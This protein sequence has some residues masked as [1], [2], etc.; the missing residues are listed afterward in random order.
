MT[1]PSLIVVNSLVVRGRVGSRA[2]AFALERLGIEPWLLPTILLPFHPGHGAGTRLSV[3]EAQFAGL[4]DDLIARGLSGVRA[5]LTGYLGTVEQVPHLL[6]LI[7]AARAANPDVL[8]CCDPVIGDAQGLYVDEALALAMLESLVPA[9]DLLCPN[10]HELAWLT[11]HPVSTNTEIIEAVSTLAS[12]T[13]LV[14]SAHEMM[15][16]NM[17]N[18]LV[19]ETRAWL[20]EARAIDKPPHGTG[21]LMSAIFTAFLLAEHAPDAALS[22]ATSCVHDILAATGPGAEEIALVAAQDRLMSPRMP[23]SLRTLVQ[24]V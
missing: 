11:G 7:A 21:D 24:A 6:R 8:V 9:A 3:P 2:Q 18:L 4:I 19:H 15:R 5:V 17:A 1:P 20:A 10:R 14:T 23:V 16:G 12:P 13:V 22:R